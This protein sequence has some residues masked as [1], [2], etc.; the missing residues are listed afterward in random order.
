MTRHV[1]LSQTE[2]EVPVCPAHFPTSLHL[3]NQLAASTAEF[4]SMFVRGGASGTFPGPTRE[5]LARDH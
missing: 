4:L 5:S 2:I 1:R 3:C